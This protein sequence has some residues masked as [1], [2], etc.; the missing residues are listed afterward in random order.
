MKKPSV[1]IPL[2]EKQDILRMIKRDS[3]SKEAIEADARR[4]EVAVRRLEQA[5][6]DAVRRSAHLLSQ[7]AS[8]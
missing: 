1:T 2:K 6:R 5:R 8:V 3:R 7:K 4:G